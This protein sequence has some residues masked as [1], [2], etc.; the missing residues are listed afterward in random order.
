[1]PPG[2]EEEAS[3][4]GRDQGGEVNEGVEP[5]TDP[6]QSQANRRRDTGNSRKCTRLYNRANVWSLSLRSHTASHLEL[7]VFMPQCLQVNNNG[8]TVTQ[9]LQGPFPQGGKYEPGFKTNKRIAARYTQV[10]GVGRLVRKPRQNTRL[11]WC[12]HL[13]SEVAEV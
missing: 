5:G 4:E 3:L 13:Q 6:K 1:M 9:H 7:S 10:L 8:L 12:L 2:L 11:G